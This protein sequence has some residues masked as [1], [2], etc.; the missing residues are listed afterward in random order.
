MPG[1]DADV[2]VGPGRRPG[3]HERPGRLP[4]PGRPHRRTPVQ[5]GGPAGPPCLPV[6]R[7]EL[8][9]GALPA[10]G[11]PGAVR[12]PL[13]GRADGRRRRQGGREDGRRPAPRVGRREG[14]GEGARRGGAGAVL[15]LHGGNQLPVPLHGRFPLLL[16]AGPGGRVGLA[17]PLPRPRPAHRGPVA[18]G[19]PQRPDG[20]DAGAARRHDRRVRSRDAD[21]EQRHRRLLPGSVRGWQAGHPPADHRCA[22]GPGCRRPSAPASGRWWPRGSPSP[23]ARS[24]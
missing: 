11:H 24:S 5:A 12:P 9:W 14:P 21:G 13:Q 15:L 10:G 23:R 2:L 16:G 6:P 8:G 22:Q 18:G 3:R 4:G 17:R 1:P 7:Q 20:P 19:A